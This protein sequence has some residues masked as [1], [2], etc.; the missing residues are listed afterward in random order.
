MPSYNKNALGIARSDMHALAK[1]QAI[2]IKPGQ[3]GSGQSVWLTAAQSRSLQKGG[4][5][6]RMSKHQLMHNIRHGGGF[7]DSLKSTAKNLYDAHKDKVKDLVV[8]QAKKHLAPVA[9]HVL[10]KI[11]ETKLGQSSLGQ[12][13]LSK[14]HDAVRKY[15]GGRARKG[16]GMPNGP[17]DL[18]AYKKTV[19]GASVGNI[20]ASNVTRRIGRRSGSTRRGGSFTLP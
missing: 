5:L 18:S 8:S 10:N 12:F 17:Y 20:G 9:H 13:G 1:G 2:R 14:A 11:G 16:K 7:W 15:S 3:L 19:G 6:L 4:G